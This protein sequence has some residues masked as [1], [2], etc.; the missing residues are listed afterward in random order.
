MS[1]NSR[2]FY[3]A[4]LYRIAAARCAYYVVAQLLREVVSHLEVSDSASGEAEILQR[5]TFIDQFRA[6]ALLLCFSVVPILAAY[7]GVA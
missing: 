4:S 6:A 3:S 7:T 1:A 2:S 5:L